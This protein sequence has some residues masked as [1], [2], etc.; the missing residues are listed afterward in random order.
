MTE[1]IDQMLKKLGAIRGGGERH[2]RTVII[3]ELRDMLSR[4]DVVQALC[5][6]LIW[7]EQDG[8]S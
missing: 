1:Q 7:K 8:I 3:E 2:R 5:D 4:R 6:D